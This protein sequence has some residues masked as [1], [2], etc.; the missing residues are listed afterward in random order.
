MV[1]FSLVARKDPAM[2]NLSISDTDREQFINFMMQKDYVPPKN[3]VRYDAVIYILKTDWLKPFHTTFYVGHST[4]L[5]QRIYG[6]GFYKGHK[7]SYQAK[8]TDATPE[9]CYQDLQSI[10]VGKYDFQECR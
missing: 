2:A 7:D 8:W 9:C 3:Q 4:D 5:K 6:N 10:A 1:R